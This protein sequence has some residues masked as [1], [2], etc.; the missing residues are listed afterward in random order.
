MVSSGY[1]AGPVPCESEIFLAWKYPKW[2]IANGSQA[3]SGPCGTEPVIRP[4]RIRMLRSPWGRTYSFIYEE[5]ASASFR[6]KR[7]IIR[8]GLE[9]ARPTAI[10]VSEPGAQMRSVRVQRSPEPGFPSVA[11]GP[12]GTRF[13]PYHSGRSEKK[14]A[15]KEDALPWVCGE[16]V[17]HPDGHRDSPE[18][19]DHQLSSAVL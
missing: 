8:K 6:A 15:K 18:I 19:R 14:C 16:R 2:T 7:G 4:H 13:P 1:Y 12:I 11:L 3:W 10:T 5:C 17:R 9:E